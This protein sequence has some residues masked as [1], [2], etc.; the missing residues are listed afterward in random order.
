VLIREREPDRLQSSLFNDPSETIGCLD[1][2]GGPQSVLPNES[3]RELLSSIY[4]EHIIQQQSNEA[5][6]TQ[7]P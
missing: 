6:A 4:V 1:V 3:Q 5:P 2:F 7:A